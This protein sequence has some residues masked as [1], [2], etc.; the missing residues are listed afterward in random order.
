MEVIPA[1]PLIT[2]TIN[3]I[4][5]SLSACSCSLPD[6]VVALVRLLSNLSSFRDGLSSKLDVCTFMVVVGVVIELI[7][8]PIDFWGEFKEYKQSFSEWA[9]G[10]IPE[11]RKPSFLPLIEFFGAVLVAVGVAGEL[12]YEHKIGAVD[13]CIQQ[14]DNARAGLLEHEAN[15]QKIRAAELEKEAAQLRE[16]AAELQ[17]SI[18][19][20]N[21]PPDKRKLIAARLKPY[22]LQF[23]WL[24]YNLSDVESNDF[25]M[26]IAETLKLAGWEPSEPEP[27]ITMREGPVPLGSNGPLPRGVVVTSTP[28]VS[29]GK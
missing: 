9:R 26:D 2:T 5:A 10:L 23:A 4:V 17:D 20:R 8:V 29:S 22:K 24:S 27:I 15:T 25:G 28:D 13:T 3:W 6:N 18:T 19:W 1:I 14:A 21:I 11:P 12:M 16:D 7:T